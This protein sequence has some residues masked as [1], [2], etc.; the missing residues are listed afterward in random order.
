MTAVTEWSDFEPK[1]RK[2]VTVSTFPPSICQEQWDGMPW[3]LSFACWILSQL[4]HSPLLHSSRALSSSLLSAIKV[5]SSAY[6]RLLIFLLAILIPV[7]DSSSLAFHMMHSVYRLNKQGDNIQPLCT[8]FPVCYPTVVLCPMLTIASWPA[9]SCLR[10]QVRCSGISISWSIFH[11]LL[12]S[13]Q[14]KAL[15]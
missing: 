12:W 4:F 7:G 5:M 2:S 9:H 14:S 11:S 6:V 1:K 8:P 10:R 15:A 3:S 13:T